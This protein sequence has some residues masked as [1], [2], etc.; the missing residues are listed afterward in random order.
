MIWLLIIPTVLFFAVLAW[1]LSTD[2]KKWIK[3]INGEQYINHRWEAFVRIMIFTPVTLLLS[4]HHYDKFWLHADG[5][6]R[7]G[8]F[9]IEL[10]VTIGMEF[11]VYWTLFDGIY[12]L[13][14]YFDWSYTG[15][16][17]GSDDAW[18]DRFQRWAGPFISQSIK[19]IGSVALILLY[20]T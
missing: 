18:L 4:L 17:E 9:W 12:N 13:L 5:V 10:L 14:R 3:Q 16:D 15:S 7:D 19:I 20:A 11:F 1:D 6:I 8:N 2:Y